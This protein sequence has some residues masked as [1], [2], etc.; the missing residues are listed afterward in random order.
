MTRGFVAVSPTLSVT[1]N[2]AAFAST[3]MAE[4]VQFDQ[5]ALFNWR[6][7]ALW[8]A[9]AACAALV[10]VLIVG[11]VRHHV[12]GVPGFQHSIIIL[13]LCTAAVTFEAL[14]RGRF[15]RTQMLHWVNDKLRRIE[16]CI[17]HADPAELR[18]TARAKSPVRAIASMAASLGAVFVSLAL[19]AGT[20]LISTSI[21]VVQ[22]I[23]LGAAYAVLIW[24]AAQ[25][26]RDV[27][28]AEAAG[29]FIVLS[30]TLL[31]AFGLA[32]RVPDMPGATQAL[33][34]VLSFSQILPFMVLAGV[35]PLILDVRPRRPQKDIVSDVRSW[36]HATQHRL[37]IS[38]GRHVTVSAGDVLCV[39]VPNTKAA[40]TCLLEWSTLQVPDGTQVAA[41]FDELDPFVPPCSPS[42]LA[43]NWLEDDAEKPPAWPGGFPTGLGRRNQQKLALS[44]ALSLPAPIVAIE[45]SGPVFAGAERGRVDALRAK[46]TATPRAIVIVATRL[47][48]G[49]D[50]TIHLEED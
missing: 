6:N 26:D 5:S 35:M 23:T 41:V 39:V 29:P 37:Q 50:Q 20:G 31:V 32:A 13:I 12:L 27:L 10:G 47:V 42:D 38:Q 11:V 46:L 49:A 43:R 1:E 44:A 25:R 40:R 14:L 45:W 16:A 8:A 17:T 30:G 48:P 15:R 24:S 21:F 2:I 7:M 9:R 28:Y 18:E 19:L 36:S 3:D 4:N 34:V 22:G 33:A